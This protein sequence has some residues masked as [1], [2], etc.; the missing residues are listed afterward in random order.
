[1][2]VEAFL[3]GILGFL[4]IPELVERVMEVH[5]PFPIRSVHDVMDID[6][7]SRKKAKEILKQI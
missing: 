3:E 4:G 1:V 6:Q 5:E 7:W 2:A